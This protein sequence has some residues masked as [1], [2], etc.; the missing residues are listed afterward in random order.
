MLHGSRGDDLCTGIL[1]LVFVGLSPTPAPGGTPDADVSSQA[2]N[3]AVADEEIR[4]DLVARVRQ[5]IAEGRYDT[6]E[7]WDAALDRLLAHMA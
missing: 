6:P 5:E 4:A 2:G 1:R 3:T 7:K